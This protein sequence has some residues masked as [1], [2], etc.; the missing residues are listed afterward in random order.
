MLRSF[1]YS[2]ELYWLSFLKPKLQ[3]K[4]F[5]KGHLKYFESFLKLRESWLW[6]ENL[7]K[8]KKVLEKQKLKDALL[9]LVDV[10]LWVYFF[11]FGEEEE[12]VPFTSRAI[13]MKI[14]SQFNPDWALVSKKG[15][16]ISFA[17]SSPS[18][19]ETAR[20]SVETSII[21]KFELNSIF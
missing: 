6:K 4:N 3:K 11:P 15:T 10:W 13:W 12:D 7:L 14:S 5:K 19:L 20:W 8:K 21:L 16:F 2:L 18:S 9:N 1:F 17:S